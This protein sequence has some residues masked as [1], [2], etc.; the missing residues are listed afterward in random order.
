ML[1]PAIASVCSRFFDSGFV[2]YSDIWDEN[3]LFKSIYVGAEGVV[4]LPRFGIL[5]FIRYFERVDSLCV[6]AEV[7]GR[8]GFVRWGGEFW[9]RY[10]RSGLHAQVF[11]FGLAIFIFLVS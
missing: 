7:F 6:G 1:D 11:R 5:L 9:R 4:C 10:Q 8:M 2:S 3:E